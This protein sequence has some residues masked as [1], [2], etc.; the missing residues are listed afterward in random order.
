MYLILLNYSSVDINT[1]ENS[2]YMYFFFL[3]NPIIISKHYIF[4]IYLKLTCS[5][6]KRMWV[7]I[8]FCR[9]H[10]PVGGF[11][12]QL[13]LAPLRE[14]TTLRTWNGVWIWLYENGKVEWGS[15]WHWSE[16][17]TELN[18]SYFGGSEPKPLVTS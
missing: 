11:A 12:W 4:F 5:K 18:C 14:E 15:T 3:Y 2:Q 16:W 10:A 9:R 13:T 17:T 8:L 1:L 7:L 6:I